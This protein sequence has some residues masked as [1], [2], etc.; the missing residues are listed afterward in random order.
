M[1]PKR[2]KNY[3]WNFEIDNVIC[4]NKKIEQLF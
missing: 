3:D 1:D 4:R 2:K